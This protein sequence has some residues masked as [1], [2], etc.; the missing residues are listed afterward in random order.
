MNIYHKIGMK[1][2]CAYVW[3]T[4]HLQILVYCLLFAVKCLE[5]IFLDGKCTLHVMSVLS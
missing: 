2:I 1:F 3:L 4:T 5:I